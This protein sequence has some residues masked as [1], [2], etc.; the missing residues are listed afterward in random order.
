MLQCQ[1]AYVLLMQNA[2]VWRVRDYVVVGSSVTKIKAQG[3]N[4]DWDGRTIHVVSGL[5]I[6]PCNSQKLYSLN[7][8]VRVTYNSH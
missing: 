7:V 1:G 6:R 3:P 2:L 4:S 8:N 5:L